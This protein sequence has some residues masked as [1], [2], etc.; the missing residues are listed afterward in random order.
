MFGKYKPFLRASILN[1]FAYKFNIIS[2]LIVCASSLLC[3]FYLWLAVYQNS[4]DEIING[5]TF[6]EM[7]SY[8]IVINIF[9][10]TTYSG[11]TDYEISQEIRNGQIAMSLIKPISY[12][13]RF[14]FS[15]LGSLIASDVM[16]GI[17]LLTIVT[18]ILSSTG[19]II[20][21]GIWVFLLNILFYLISQILASMLFD[22]INYIFGLISFYTLASFGLN[23]IKTAIINFLSGAMIPI[24]FFPSWAVLILGYLPFV[25]MAQ[26]PTLIFLNKMDITQ[27]LWAIGL[28]IIWLVV[29]E[30]LAHLFFK[31]AIRNVTIQ[32]G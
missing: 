12:R 21:P 7:I 13:L 10:F 11:S 6:H 18:Y 19:F 9:T 4:P 2:W 8:T 3:L 5:F 32:G 26:N 20:L 23:Q 27:I 30:T 16:I 24:A 1:T 29:L 28:Q 14:V 31:K 25:G 22:A 15:N 17:P